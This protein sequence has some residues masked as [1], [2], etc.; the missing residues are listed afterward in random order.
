MKCAL[1]EDHEATHGI[2]C[3]LCEDDRLVSASLDRIRSRRGL[4]YKNSERFSQENYVKSYKA[5]IAKENK[6]HPAA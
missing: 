5:L 4:N 3:D 2:L 6:E 1:C